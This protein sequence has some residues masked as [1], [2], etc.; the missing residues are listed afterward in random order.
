VGLGAG[1]FDRVSEVFSDNSDIEV[2]E[3]NAGGRAVDSETYYN[4]GTEAWADL[5]KGLKDEKIGGAV[6][7][8]KK[9]ISQLTTRK[10]KFKSDGR[11]ILESKEDIRKKGGKSPDWG[12]AVAI[13]FY[14]GEE[15]FEILIGRA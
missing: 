3:F 8:N 2:I 12:D 9:L 4:V 7:N 10:Y 5:A 1:V 6:F 11:M 13:A 14:E 15:P